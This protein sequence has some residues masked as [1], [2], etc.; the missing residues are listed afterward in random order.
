MIWQEKGGLDM[1]TRVQK[2]LQGILEKHKPPALPEGVEGKIREILE[3]AE[4]RDG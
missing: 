4:G 1:E 2:R 3:A